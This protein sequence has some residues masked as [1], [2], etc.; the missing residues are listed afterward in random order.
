MEEEGLCVDDHGAKP[1]WYDQ[2]LKMAKAGETFAA[3]GKKFGVSGNFV[4]SWLVKGRKNHG[5][6]VNPDAEL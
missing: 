5:K 4:A 3:I 1:K 6:I 2:A